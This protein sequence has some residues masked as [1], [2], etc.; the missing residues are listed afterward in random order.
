M[1]ANAVATYNPLT[2]AL[3]AAEA[4]WPVFACRPGEKFPIA[5]A[6]NDFLLSPGDVDDE[7][8]W[9]GKILPQ[10]LVP[11]RLHP[12]G[13]QKGG[14][15]K[16]TTNPDVIRFIWNLHPEATP[17]VVLP[18]RWMIIDVD[19][20][21]TT[22][23]IHMPKAVMA[24]LKEH[25]A[26]SVQTGGGGYHF[27]LRAPDDGSAEA[28]PPDWCRQGGLYSE[29][30]ENN[31]R[32]PC[33]DLKTE[34]AGYVV[35]PNAKL[36]AGSYTVLKGHWPPKA[37][38]P[39]NLMPDDL[40]EVVARMRRTL[41][42]TN[43][44]TDGTPKKTKAKKTSAAKNDTDLRDGEIF[45]DVREA[46]GAAGIINPEE[47]LAA[48]AQVP[49]GQRHNAYRETIG[50]WCQG[51]PLDKA[52]DDLIL[53]A[54]NQRK[55]LAQG[56]QNAA[57]RDVLGLGAHCKAEQIKNHGEDFANGIPSTP[58][59]PEA[60]EKGSFKL[61][62]NSREETVP[63]IKDTFAVTNRGSKTCVVYKAKPEIAYPSWA[64]IEAASADSMPYFWQVNRKTKQT[65]RCRLRWTT[66]TGIGRDR[67]L[68]Q[69]LRAV[70]AYKPPGVDEDFWHSLEDHSFPDGTFDPNRFINLWTGFAVEE[71]E[72]AADEEIQTAIRPWTDHIGEVF[73]NGNI[74]NFD[75]LLDW[76]AAMIQKPGQHAG[77]IVV[78][79][80]D[81]Q[82]AGK[83]VAL[84]PLFKIFKPKDTVRLQA[85]YS[86][87]SRFNAELE[88]KPFVQA[89]E[90]IFAGSNKLAAY[91]KGQVT[92]DTFRVERKGFD[93]ILT[94]NVMHLVV[95][96]NE[97]NAAH[98][99]GND[100]RHFVLDAAN[101]RALTLAKDVGGQIARTKYFGRIRNTSPAALFTML[102]RRVLPENWQFRLPP[103]T[104]ARK[105]MAAASAGPVEQFIF[106]AIERGGFLLSQ[107]PT[108]NQ[109]T[110]KTGA[111][112][113]LPW[114]RTMNVKD[115]VQA[116]D[117]FR[118]SSRGT[119]WQSIRK[120]FLAKT[121][122][123]SH[124][125]GQKGRFI[126]WK[127]TPAESGELIDPDEQQNPVSTE[128]SRDV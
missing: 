38:Q 59:A 67:E 41:S 40:L 69:E 106:G 100:R 127:V 128:A 92:E 29:P 104:A 63:S 73:C 43:H 120:E 16:A 60:P 20:D 37:D 56:D 51:L 9:E 89:N 111:M 23:L 93:P 42:S 109:H 34:V 68:L 12:N 115:L 84:T 71:Q 66:E 125:T 21:K 7:V 102:R 4:G 25:A 99:E 55:A 35:I 2:L 119:N 117:D 78:V 105:R 122:G 110:P 36:K 118:K 83:D 116:W 45:G 107:A 81:R 46:P 112:F 77:T 49:L 33:G 126:T 8:D 22:G 48:L 70:V 15:R 98:I 123:V 91:L 53:R 11:D 1:P 17:G 87:D 88:N 95:T 28:A 50:R 27:W 94:C 26:L 24:R 44:N 72:Q 5:K 10:F 3:E 75:W 14:H 82:G 18:R 108:T 79:R 61:P 57:Y 90:A 103:M 31:I 6:G 13:Q 96:S 54:A 65:Q 101:H 30:D 58:P 85:G 39:P 124:R 74:E 113:D 97:R 64:A 32:R 47:D 80:S 52:L 86:L 19:K 121:G 114:T 76:F 62:Y